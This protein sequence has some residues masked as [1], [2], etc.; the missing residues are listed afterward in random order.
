MIFLNFKILLQPG[1]N[2]FLFE[3][4]VLV[5]WIVIVNLIP[6][7]VRAEF[8][9]HKIQ[10]WI[11]YF[12]DLDHWW[13]LFSVSV[14]LFIVGSYFFSSV[15][16]KSLLGFISILLAQLNWIG[17]FWRRS[18]NFM[19]WI[20]FIEYCSVGQAI[21]RCLLLKGYCWN[22]K[23]IIFRVKCFSAQSDRINLH[24]SSFFEFC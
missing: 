23:S 7:P 22:F 21:I 2:T 8:A 12:S 14:A 18:S 13:Y 6:I 20:L 10:E 17:L 4:A 16:F 24:H 11:S 3:K 15:F 5:I 19:Y 1:L 9:E